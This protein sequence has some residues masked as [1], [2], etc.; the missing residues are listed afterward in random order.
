[1]QLN[2]QT[3]ENYGTIKSIY[4]GEASQYNALIAANGGASSGFSQNDIDTY[5]YKVE[6][7][8]E[9]GTWSENPQPSDHGDAFLYEIILKIRRMNSAVRAWRSY[10]YNKEIIALVYDHQGNEILFGSDYEPLSFSGSKPT[11]QSAP[12]GSFYD[13]KLSGLS[14]LPL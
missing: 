2:R 7:E 11:E 9:K 14:R 1:M 8:F 13:V 6:P 12:I 5:L 10:W 4:I 3:G